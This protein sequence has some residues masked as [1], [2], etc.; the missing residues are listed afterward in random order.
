MVKAP[1]TYSP[2]N[3]LKNFNNRKNIVLKEM[4]KENYIS[5]EE[6]QNSI[7]ESEVCTNRKN[8]ESIHKRNKEATVSRNKSRV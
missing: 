1:N 4:V 2:F 5:E 3:N 8:V 7:K 6:Y